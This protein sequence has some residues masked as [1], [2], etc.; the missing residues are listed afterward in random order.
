MVNLGLYLKASRARQDE[1]QI[2]IWFFES[3]CRIHYWPDTIKQ[4]RL[5]G[6]SG[7]HDIHTPAQAR[8]YHH[9]SFQ[10][11]S[12]TSSVVEL[13]IFKVPSTM[14]KLSPI[15]F[16]LM[17]SS[18]LFFALTD[19]NVCPCSIKYASFWASHCQKRTR[20]VGLLSQ[21]A[22]LLAR[23]LSPWF[24]S[25]VK[26]IA[27]SFSTRRV[28]VQYKVSDTSDFDAV[29]VGSFSC[30]LYGKVF[31]AMSGKVSFLLW[32]IANSS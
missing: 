29:C 25:L 2:W 21:K 6:T 19:M 24:K 20:G 32:I 13:C 5:E 11:R 17:V 9:C 10:V 14:E 27:Q 22:L 15:F 28:F 7:A 23:K 18:V 3:S 31:S 8:P 12:R 26:E 4:L 16:L 30:W 1:R